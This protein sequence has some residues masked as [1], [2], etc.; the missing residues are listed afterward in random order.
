M[1][2]FWYVDKAEL[3]IYVSKALLEMINLGLIVV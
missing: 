3:I 1:C 2:I